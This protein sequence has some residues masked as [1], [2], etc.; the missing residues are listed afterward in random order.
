MVREGRHYLCAD[1]Q[2]VEREA[3]NIVSDS[4]KSLLL[5]KQGELLEGYTDALSD[6][7]HVHPFVLSRSAKGT[8]L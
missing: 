6:Y 8:M 1:C 2:E 3:E 4:P 5:L 7:M